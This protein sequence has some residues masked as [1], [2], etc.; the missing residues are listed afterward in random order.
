MKKSFI[1]FVVLSVTTASC[2][3]DIFCVN[4]NGILETQPRNAT[5][6]NHIENSTAADVIYKKDDSPGIT[7]VAESNLL[8]Y[9]VTEIV[10][11]KLEIRTEPRTMCLDYTKQPV[12]TVT[13]PELK[14]IESSG[15]GTFIADTMSANPNSIKLSGSGDIFIGSISCND[16][17]A[18]IYGSGNIEITRGSFQNADLLITGSGDIDIKGSSNSG[19]LRITG[20]GDIKSGQFTL[21]TA[22]ETISG[23]GNIFTWVGN[24]LTA[25]IS[26]SGNI[27][28]KGNPTINQTITGSGKIIRN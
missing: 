14:N 23:S 18:S 27:Y 2:I 12:I 28:L 16:L 9:I 22:N 15:S 6:F 24:N 1:I 19:H 13:S 20:S 7:V 11:G 25:E 4:G 8:E 5:A 17:S 21:G 10:N 26:G 3:K